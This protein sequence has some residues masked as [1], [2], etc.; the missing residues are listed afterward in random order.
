MVP[1]LTKQKR[2]LLKKPDVEDINAANARL[3]MDVQATGLV[4]K[5]F[6]DKFF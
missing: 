2:I 4:S 5:I 3:K 6:K 1:K